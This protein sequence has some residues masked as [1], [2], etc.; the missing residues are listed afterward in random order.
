MVCFSNTRLVPCGNERKRVGTR[1]YFIDVYMCTMELIRVCKFALF[2]S[3]DF[4]LFLF[5]FEIFV[6]NFC[7]IETIGCGVTVVL[8][9]D[10]V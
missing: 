3:P 4:G 5:C 1:G 8:Q 7:L 6:L 2:L 9:L 10:G